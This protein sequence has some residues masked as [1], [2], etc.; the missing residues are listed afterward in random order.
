M[1]HS[2]MDYGEFPNFHN[3]KCE[4]HHEEIKFDVK[5]NT[6]DRLILRYY[7]II[8]QLSECA[9]KIFAYHIPR[10]LRHFENGRLTTSQ[11]SPKLCI[12]IELVMTHKLKCISSDR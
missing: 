6:Y 10:V 9:K 2:I 1:V 11:T 8:A 5:H 7:G 4:Q 12:Y 3:D